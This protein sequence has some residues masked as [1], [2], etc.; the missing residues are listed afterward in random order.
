[1]RPIRPEDEPL[2]VRFH[3]SLSERSV[4][5]RYFEAMQLSQRVAHERLLRVCFNDY[6]Q[7]LALIADRTGT[8]GSHEIIGIVRLTR[9]HGKNEAEMA[10]IVSDAYQRQGLGTELL[11]R[12]V[13]VARQEGLDRLTAD[14][15]AGNYA[16]QKL[17]RKA[18][19]RLTQRLNDDVVRAELALR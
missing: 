13:E 2:V 19:F 17:C 4:Y 16:M 15:L 8:D 10:M 11:T 7:E 3:Q 18:G 9:V 6:D 14:I 12:L 5:L 1:M